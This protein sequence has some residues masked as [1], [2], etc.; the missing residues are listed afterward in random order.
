M[1]VGDISATP[2]APFGADIDFDLRQEL[3]PAQRVVLKDLYFSHKI[4]RFRNQRLSLADQRRVMSHVGNVDPEASSVN[5]LTPDDKVLGSAMLHYHSDMSFL[6]FPPEGLSLHALDVED[7]TSCTT[8]VNGVQTYQR[9][10]PELRTEIHQLQA[11]A[12]ANY[13][14]NCPDLAPF[15]PPSR[16]ISFQRKAVMT[17]PVT[18]EPILYV[19]GQ[20]T[21]RIAGL[22]ERESRALL[23]ELCGYLYEAAYVLTHAW[24]NGDFLMW[25]NLALQ[26]GRPSL[27]GLTRR[28]LQRVSNSSHPALDQILAAGGG[29]PEQVERVS[30]LN[31]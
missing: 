16:M 21:S 11:V 20:Q 29:M 15:D 14:E 30:A 3:S 19:S 13:G 25:D 1:I 2:I 18:G 31:S 12:V 24:T 8:F 9:L 6:P 28:K 26:H 22:S 4:L 5:V 10:P 17:H 27:R 23:D 7:G